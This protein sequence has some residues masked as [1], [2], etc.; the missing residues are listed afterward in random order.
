MIDMEADDY[1]MKKKNDKEMGRIDER[2]QALI[3]VNGPSN[4]DIKILNIFLLGKTGTGKSTIGNLLLDGA[5]F[6]EHGGAGAGTT[7]F[8]VRE[9]NVNGVTVRVADTPG[10]LDAAIPADDIAIEMLRVRN[11]NMLRIC[12]I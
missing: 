6:K 12:K 2:V 8:S 4:K 3:P 5:V 1:M 10:S 11:C 9:F 7:T